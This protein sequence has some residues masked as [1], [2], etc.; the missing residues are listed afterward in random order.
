MRP[1]LHGSDGGGG[2][3]RRRALIHSLCLLSLCERSRGAKMKRND[4]V[5]WLFFRI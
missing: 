2:P 3:R 4:V 5:G 1:A